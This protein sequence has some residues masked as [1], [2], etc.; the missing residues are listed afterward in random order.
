MPFPPGGDGAPAEGVCCADRRA[1]VPVPGPRGGTK[2]PGKRGAPLLTRLDVF[3]KHA[4]K[5]PP[6]AAN[7]TLSL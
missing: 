6:R 5:T 1:A 3:R 7:V 2:L 4:A